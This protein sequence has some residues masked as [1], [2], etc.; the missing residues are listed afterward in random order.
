MAAARKK[1][2]PVLEFSRPPQDRS[3][4]GEGVAACPVGEPVQSSLKK[5][6]NCTQSKERFQTRELVRWK[7]EGL[8][9]SVESQPACHS[10]QDWVG[11]TLFYVF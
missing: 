8:G 5:A 11:T 2:D 7:E 3:F 10:L 4:K 1:A 6:G 9:H